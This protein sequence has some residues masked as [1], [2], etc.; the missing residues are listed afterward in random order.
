MSCCPALT[1]LEELVDCFLSLMRRD[2]ALA[3]KRLEAVLHG[4]LV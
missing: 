1:F 4:E 3:N 2:L